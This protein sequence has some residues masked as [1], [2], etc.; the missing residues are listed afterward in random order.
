MSMARVGSFETSKSA[1]NNAERY[2]PQDCTL[3][4]WPWKFKIL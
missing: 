2:N 1:F 4:R 3:Y